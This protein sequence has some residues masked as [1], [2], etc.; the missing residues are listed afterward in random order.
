M[1][2][3]FG[4]IGA[5]SMIAQQAIKQFENQGIIL[6]KADLTG[7]IPVDITSRE[8]VQDFFRAHSQN[9]DWV[10]LFSA[11]TDVGGAEK[12][13]AEGEQS[14]CWRINVDGVKNVVNAAR[15]FGKKL[16]F[17]STDFVFDGTS[18]PYKEKDPPGPNFS[19]VSFY[20]LTKIKGEEYIQ[21]TLSMGHYI[22][23][24]IAYPYSGV[25]TGKEDLILKDVRWYKKGQPF[26]LW[27]NHMIGPTYIPDIPRA[28]S[29]II[30]KKG[31]GIFHLGSPTITSSYGFA[32][33]LLTKYEGKEIQ[34]KKGKLT[35]S[36]G[37]HNPYPVTLN[38]G[39][40]VKKI[41]AIGFDPTDWK[42]GIELSLANLP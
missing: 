31:T 13:K 5:E 39:F 42:K 25:N 19:K 36:P 16:V 4:I 22:I 12:Q 10:I 29:L 27:T 8:S 38:G 33:E 35:E 24:R 6:T 18:G 21:N 11:Y 23:L 14:L 9:F 30:K 40:I 26:A 41:R 32:R 3:R 15:E 2:Q 28:I 1:N 17:I 7:N 37:N 34:L 20:G